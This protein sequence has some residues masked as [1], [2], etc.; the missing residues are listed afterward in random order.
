MGEDE[1]G[2][3][4]GGEEMMGGRILSSS[5]LTLAAHGL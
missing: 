5:P 3:W 4:R 2:H 1:G